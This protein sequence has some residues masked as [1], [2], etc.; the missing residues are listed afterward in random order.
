MKG[1]MLE[2]FDKM[3]GAF[4]LLLVLAAL[5]SRIW[6]NVTAVYPFEYREMVTVKFARDFAY[7]INPYIQPADGLPV[8]KSIYGFV[9]PL[10]MAPFVRLFGNSNALLICHFVITGITVA[11]VLLGFILLRERVSFRCILGL[12]LLLLLESYSRGGAYSAAFPDTTGVTLLLL[13][14]FLIDR[15][16]KFET[17]V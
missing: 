1:R 10:V 13:L 12:S 11:G 2:R 14:C 17:K 6:L 9:T 3:A 8:V 4:C 16:E 7:G 15:D 5:G